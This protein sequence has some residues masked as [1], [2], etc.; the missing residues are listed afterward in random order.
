MDTT[1]ADLSRRLAES[2]S[3]GGRVPVVPSGAP[4]AAFGWA[5]DGPSTIIGSVQSAGIE[6]GSI[7]YFRVD[8][9][10]VPASV[11]EGGTKPTLASVTS[12]NEALVKYAGLA[13]FPVER[14]IYSSSAIVPIVADTLF[15][16]VLLAADA[17][18]WATLGTDAGITVPAA[19]TWSAA[20]LAGIGAVVANGGNPDVLIMSATDY[21]AAVDAPGAG[22]SMSPEGA[23]QSLFGL[24]ILISAG[25]GTASGTAYVADSRALLAVE[26]AGGPVAVLDTTSGL[27]TNEIRLAVELFA[28]F[29]ITLPGSVAKISVT[30]TPLGARTAEPPRRHAA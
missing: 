17:A 13:S 2:M 15:S 19:A 28:A 20:I 5:A 6:G 14:A 3:T 25:G 18:A 16:Q 1:V 22:Y 4:I 23:K 30:T 21:A 10:G 7:S 24:R 9:S 12:G 8:R 26:D 11:P 29:V 27:S